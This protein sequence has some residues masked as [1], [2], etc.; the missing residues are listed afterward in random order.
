MQDGVGDQLI[1]R[2]D[3]IISGLG[4]HSQPFQ[5]PAYEPPGGTDGRS[6][7][8]LLVGELEGD[9]GASLVEVDVD[10]V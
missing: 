5:H 1:G 4:A 3:Q 10:V 6:G 8:L 9:H 7:V 2:Q